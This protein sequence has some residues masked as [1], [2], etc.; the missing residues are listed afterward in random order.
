L[1][2]MGM[3]AGAEPLTSESQMDP[4]ALLTTFESLPIGVQ[5]NPSTIDQLEYFTPGAGLGIASVAGF[6]ANGTVVSDR[7]LLPRPQGVFGGDSYADMVMLLPVP[8]REIGLGWFDPNLAGNRLEVYSVTGAL[9]ESIDV[10]TFPPGGC[11][12]TFVGIRRPTAEI[13]RV[14]VRVGA[15]DDVYG[16]DNVR[17]T[18][19]VI[20]PQARTVC[21]SGSAT[22]SVTTAG[23]GPFTYLWRKDGTPIDPLANSSAATATLVL[24]NVGPADE[25]SYD[26]IVTNACGSVTS[27][28]ATL[29]I[30]A[31]D[32][33]CDGFLDFFDYS[34]FVECFETEVC[35]GG[36]AD[37]NGDGFVDF[38]DYADFVGAFE[39]GC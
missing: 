28:A 34:D 21:R 33:N 14:V 35:G 4:C 10:P 15:S 13:V 2:F 7:S 24:T 17:V 6:S 8:A 37:F 3:V 36:S 27:D 22:F 12:A 5:P 1:F 23:A 20:P 31:A 11:C 29:T 25:A 38:F 19:G 9:L 39:T 32:F 18:Y 16:I 30:C 26:C